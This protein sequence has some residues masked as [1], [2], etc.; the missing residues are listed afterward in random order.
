LK[1][2]NYIVFI[3]VSWTALIEAKCSNLACI[4]AALKLSNRTLQENTGTINNILNTISTLN[5]NTQSIINNLSAESCNQSVTVIRQVDIPYLITTPGVYCLGEDVTVASG[6]GITIG[7]ASI[8]QNKVTIDFNNHTM[9]G[10]GADYGVTVDPTRF[11]LSAAAV[12]IKNGTIIGMNENGIG[13]VFGLFELNIENMTLIANGGPG[14]T[15]ER[16]GLYT[17]NVF[18]CTLQ[19]IASV[20]F[21]GLS[22]HGFY[23]DNCT[24]LNIENCSARLNGL[25][26]FT[27]PGT[28]FRGTL[29]K[30]CYAAANS[31]D[32][33][34]VSTPACTVINCTSNQNRLAGFNS[35]GSNITITQCTA[36][37]NNEDGF[38]TSG[39]T[40]LIYNN[41]SNG[42]D[43]SASATAYGFNDNGANNRT[44]GNFAFDNNAGLNNFSPSITNVAVN[45]AYTDPI[46]YTA[47]ISE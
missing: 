9:T 13:I 18:N 30:N 37:Q 41:S 19:N 20:G 28:I 43:V 39:T 6:N 24:A 11:I 33:F 29:L 47:N 36:T 12:T 7:T 44:Y 25:S 27:V 15:A 46:N 31:L 22:G 42:N 4:C 32:G 16:G 21:L 35:S 40:N 17:T 5:V 2:I 38:V 23:L 34:N 10:A 45:P 26:G 3:I 1:Y 14:L 8:A